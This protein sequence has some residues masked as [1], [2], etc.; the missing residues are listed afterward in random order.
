MRVERGLVEERD[1]VVL[2][3]WLEG[4]SEWVF[5]VEVWRL[6]GWG[7][8]EERRDGEAGIGVGKGR[9]DEVGYYRWVW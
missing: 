1:V 3:W 7:W 2:W 8:W 6:G 9:W 4:F 5:E